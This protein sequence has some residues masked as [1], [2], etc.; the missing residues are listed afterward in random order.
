MVTTARRE[1]RFLVRDLDA[2]TLAEEVFHQRF[3]EILRKAH[4]DAYG[5]GFKH[6]GGGHVSRRG[7]NYIAALV[8]S[9]TRFAREAGA[10]LAKGEIER[11]EALQRVELYAN[12]VRGTANEGFRE[13]SETGGYTFDWMLGRPEEHCLECPSYAGR[14]PW[15]PSELPTVPG[16]GGTT[17]GS[18]CLC[19][20]VRS[21]GR[22]GFRRLTEAEKP[23]PPRRE[24]EEIIKAPLVGIGKDVRELLQARKSIGQVVR[25]GMEDVEAF[26]VP[27]IKGE[28]GRDTLGE[29]DPAFRTI[30]IKRGTEHLQLALAHEFGHVLFYDLLLRAVDA[31][32]N[33]AVAALHK[34]LQGSE[35]IAEIRRYRAMR[36][37]N[38]K[39]YD[40]LLRDDEILCRAFAQ[41]I[42][43]KTGNPSMTA[44][45][46]KL[47][48]AS[49]TAPFQWEEADFDP[50]EVHMT[51]LLRL[52]G[53]AK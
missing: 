50:I 33:S 5:V 52:I 27:A 25:A 37:G 3:A 47:A 17:C 10:L 13:A 40:Y 7:N 1:L 12:R 30:K 14:N 38:E 20:L 51:A 44:S 26:L 8:N 31:K 34:A 35:S 18:N 6:G 16:A 36:D 19:R 22:E 41:Y 2:G 11:R 43:R 29:C 45:V 4:E 32:G 42:Q 48:A 46:K 24:V 53:V 28:S 39:F 23:V 21:D 9:E 15:R 49:L